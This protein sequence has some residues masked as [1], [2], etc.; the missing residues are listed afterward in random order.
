[1]TKREFQRKIE[2]D[3]EF[4]ISFIIQNNPKAVWEN[5]KSLNIAVTQNPEDIYQK[6]MQY[7]IDPKYRSYIVQALQVPIKNC[8]L[9]DTAREALED[10]NNVNTKSVTIPDWVVDGEDNP[11]NPD[12]VD[13]NTSTWNWD[14]LDEAFISLGQIFG[15][16]GSNT[17]DPNSPE[18]QQYLAEQQRKKQTTTIAIVAV[19]IVIVVGLS[20]FLFRKK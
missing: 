14:W 17:Y 13:N 20:I 7:G 1:M 11:N 9:S 6:V 18:Y 16:I 10:A 8:Q 19:V 5:L 15:G 12:P 2:S 4:T 3:P